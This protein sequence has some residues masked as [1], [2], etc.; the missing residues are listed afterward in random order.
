[1]NTRHVNPNYIAQMW[2][3]VEG[4]LAAALEHSAGEYDVNQL[5]VMLVNG[6]QSLLVVE[7]DGVINGAIAV[8]F[9][10]YPNDRIAFVTAVGGRWIV[11]QDAWSQFEDWCR[12]M[13]C[14]K[15]RGAA[16]ESV[17]RLWKRHFGVEPKY[18]IVEK[19]L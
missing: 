7:S 14:T 19:S 15:I 8:A 16:Y 5:K 4:M 9:E 2:P 6:S 13:G 10:N 11:K 18:L 12:A 3:Q 17:A 1:M